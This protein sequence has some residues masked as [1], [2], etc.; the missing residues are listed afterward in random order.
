MSHMVADST[1]VSG[2]VENVGLAVGII[3]LASMGA[4]VGGS[5]E[6]S[7]GQLGYAKRLGHSRLSWKYWS[8]ISPADY[9]S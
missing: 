4:K 1:I 7:L 3:F 8:P 5:T 2:I 9:T 6:P